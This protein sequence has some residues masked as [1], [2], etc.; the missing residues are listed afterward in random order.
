MTGSMFTRSPAFPGR[1]MVG[2][3]DQVIGTA[4]TAHYSVRR[5]GQT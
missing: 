1:P 5:Y 2:L 3:L 4:T